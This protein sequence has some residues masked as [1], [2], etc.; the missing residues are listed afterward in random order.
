M[1]V[2]ALTRAELVELDRCA[3]EELAIP[4]VVLM[5][6]AGRG[7]AEALLARFEALHG[8]LPGTV[9][10][11]CGRGNNGGDGY[12]VARHLHA[13]G[14]RVRLASLCAGDRLS[15]D[16]RTMRV[17]CERSGLPIAT[18]A[19]PDPGWLGEV[20]DAW[21]DAILGTGFQGELRDE[22]LAWVRALDARPAALRVALDLPSGLDADCGVACPIALHVDL[23]ATFAAPKVGFSA[24]SAAAHLG[25]IEVLGIGTPPELVERVRRRRPGA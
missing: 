19:S 24:P 2:P 18:L 3:I 16:A 5:E 23:T 7:A 20:G 10:I 8:R 14:V 22:A 9:S 1:H 13:R 11:V 15:G 6:N 12:V 21:V 25:W 4:G 17:I